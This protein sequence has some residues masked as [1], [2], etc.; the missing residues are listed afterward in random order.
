MYKSLIFI[1]GI[2]FILILSISSPVRN[3]VADLLEIKPVSESTLTNLKHNESNFKYFSNKYS[4]PIYSLKSAYASEINRRIYISY[5]TDY[6]QDLFFKSNLYPEKLIEYSLKSSIKSRYFNITQQD[7]GLG[8]IRLE[9]AINIVEKYKS[10]FHFL[11]NHKDIVMYLLTERGNIHIGSLVIK[12]GIKRFGP[13]I[14][15]CNSISKSA[16]LFSY[17]KQGDSY[18]IRYL[19]NSK[20]KSPPMPDPE[21]LKIVKY[22]YLISD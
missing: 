2:S 21:G 15:Q 7:I 3:V 14:S 17:F 9:T 19:I 13:H 20:F 22:L 10:E 6:C 12:E 16:I 5:I 1:I 8:N 18:Y 4:I 11:K